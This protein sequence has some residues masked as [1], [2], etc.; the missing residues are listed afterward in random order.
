MSK[1]EL[2]VCTSCGKPVG[3][4]RNKIS[5]KEFNISG[6]C[7]K[8]QDSVLT[9]FRDYMFKM[10]DESDEGWNSPNASN[11]RYGSA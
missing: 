8:C 1:G 6:M 3:E 4:L 2:P 5:E 11:G 10:A 7:Q 9:R